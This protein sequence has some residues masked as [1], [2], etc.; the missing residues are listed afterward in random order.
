M[1][2][3]GGRSPD[4]GLYRRA[5]RRGTAGFDDLDRLVFVANRTAP[6]IAVV[7]SASDRLI[8]HVVAAAI[9]HQFV[10]A[11]QRNLLIASHL[12]PDA[13]SIVDLRADETR[14]LDLDVSPEQLAI[15]PASDVV[16]I[17]S[18]RDDALLLLSPGD[19]PAIRRIDALGQ[20][21]DLVFDRDGDFLLVASTATAEIA[22]IEVAAA[23]V[24]ERI[25]LAA[26]SVVPGPG[27]ELGFAL[28]GENGLVSV[29]DL[30]ARSHMP[31]SLCPAPPS[32]RTRPPTASMSWC[33][34]RATA[35]SP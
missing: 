21:G 29:I 1:S 19:E 32:R 8:G 23:R 31:R 5:R 28:H 10:L 26:A 15:G 17:S 34:T 18:A 9:P 30:R 13:L 14:R 2:P 22:V 33:R 3:L 7:D 24:V 4:A 35:R 27:G 11:D 20:P 12:A 6:E 25:A 16:A